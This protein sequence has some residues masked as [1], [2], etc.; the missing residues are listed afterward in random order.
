[1]LAPAGIVVVYPWWVTLIFHLCTALAGAGITYAVAVHRVLAPR[2]VIRQS[3]QYALARKTL[4]IAAALADDAAGRGARRAT[5]PQPERDRLGPAPV[6]RGAPGVDRRRDQVPGA[7]ACLAGSPLLPPGVRRAGGVAV[8]VGTHPVPDRSQRAD[9]AGGQADRRRT[10][11]DDGGRARGGHGAGDA[12]AGLGAAWHGR[13]A[14]ST[15]RH[16]HDADVVGHAARPGLD[17]RALGGRPAA[18]RRGRVV[19]MHGRRA[20]RAAVC[21][22]GRHEGVA[23]RAGPGREAIRGA[24]HDRRSRAAVVDCRPGQPGT[25]RRPPAP[26]AGHADR[27]VAGDGLAHQPAVGQRRH[28]AGRRVPRLRHVPRR[29][30]RHVHQRRHDAPARPAA[31]SGGHEI[32]RGPRAGARRHGRGLLRARHAARA[33]RRHQGRARRT[34]ERPRRAHALPTRGATGGAPPASGHRR[35][36]S[37]T[38]R[39]P[40]A[41]RSW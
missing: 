27:G 20:V 36:S 21:Q 39:C 35:R 3:L 28:A 24:L 11:P 18:A 17:R 19:A 12:G 32:P 22:R 23:G 9:G 6:L 15:R 2:V 8:T 4:G 7:R 13:H 5:R 41:R 33:R 25:G 10:A 31:S 37:T 29:R 34:A 30:G 1:M 40:T 14:G 16:R 26:P 38:A